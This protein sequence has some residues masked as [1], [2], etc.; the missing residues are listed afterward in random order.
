MSVGPSGTASVLTERVALFSAATAAIFASLGLV[1][2]ALVRLARSYSASVLAIGLTGLLGVTTG[3]TWLVGSAQLASHEIND[4]KPR[5]SEPS[6][7]SETPLPPIA[8]PAA[9]TCP[10]DYKA[11]AERL[12]VEVDALKRKIRWLEHREKLSKVIDNSFFKLDPMPTSELVS[13]QKGAWYTIRLK[14][15]GRQL[16]RHYE[17]VN[18]PELM[19][20]VRIAC[21][22]SA[23]RLSNRGL[24]PISTLRSQA[25]RK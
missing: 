7:P 3:T 12:G 14:V 25:R 18:W 17:S 1:A 10:F 8:C 20:T 19:V 11:E 9:I 22:R 24:S 2:L 5:V 16:G 15:N 6:K 13:G 23:R 4:L 21:R